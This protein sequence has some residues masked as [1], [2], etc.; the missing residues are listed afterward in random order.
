MV[1]GG[2]L[3]SSA[4][5]SF[6]PGVKYLGGMPRIVASPDLLPPTHPSRPGVKVTGI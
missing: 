2:L 5:F 4:W 6:L 1:G 3:G